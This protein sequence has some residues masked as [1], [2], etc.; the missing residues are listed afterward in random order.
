[1]VVENVLV[2]ARIHSARESNMPIVEEL[3]LVLICA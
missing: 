2:G 1:M 3:S